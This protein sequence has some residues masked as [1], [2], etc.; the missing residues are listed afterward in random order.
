GEVRVQHQGQKQIVPV[1]DDDQLTAGTLEGRMVDQVLLGAVRADVAL[2]GELTRDDFLN[3]DLLV[4]AIAAIL[5]LAARLGDLLRAA[6]GAPRLDDG[7][8][9]HGSNLQF[10]SDNVQREATRAC[11]ATPPGA[12]GP[13]RRGGQTVLR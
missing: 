10:T 5:L 12:E 2:E 9:G 4:P 6:E 3:R 13:R 7:L 11:G 8:A 1:V